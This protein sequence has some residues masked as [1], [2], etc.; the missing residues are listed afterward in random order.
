MLQLAACLGIARVSLAAPAM[1]LVGF[2]KG[3]STSIPDGWTEITTFRRPPNDFS[4]VEDGKK[5]VLQV[6]SLGT[7]SALL[8]DLDLHVADFPILAWRWKVNRVVG[9]AIERQKNRNDAAARIRVIFGKSVSPP[10]VRPPQIEEFLKSIGIQPQIREP[11][12]FKIDYIWANRLAPEEVIDFPGEKNHKIVAV[13]SGKA[14]I[15]RWVW[16]KRNLMQDYQAYFGAL[17]S[18]LIGI[19]VLTDTDDTNEGIR[20]A[21]SSLVLMSK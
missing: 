11:S 2:T 10:P 8:K 9:M 12:G 21:Y 14:R 16:E 5:I 15:T 1:Q 13:E 19:V 3:D 7:A 17:P 20:A 4:L 6:R 18:R